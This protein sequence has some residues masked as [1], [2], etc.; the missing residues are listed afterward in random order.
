MAIWK[1]TV[2]ND[3]DGIDPTSLGAIHCADQN[4]GYC[5]G[6]GTVYYGYGSHWTT[7][8]LGDGEYVHCADA[9]IG[10]DPFYQQ[11][12]DCYIL[13]DGTCTLP[14]NYRENHCKS[15]SFI[16]SVGSQCLAM[17]S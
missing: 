6:P 3:A 2:C 10:C 5:F 17:L 1:Y 16:L 8:E 15:L 9:D 7:K 12:K 11:W 14:H 4:N 13:E